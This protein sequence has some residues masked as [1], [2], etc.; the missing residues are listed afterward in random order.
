MRNPAR[1]DQCT[2]QSEAEFVDTVH[3]NKSPQQR[4]HANCRT[5]HRRGA[6]LL[7]PE[8]IDAAAKSAHGGKIFNAALVAGCLYKPRGTLDPLCFHSGFHLPSALHGPIGGQLP[9]CS[10]H[11]AADQG[12]DELVGWLRGHPAPEI[13]PTPANG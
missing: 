10:K 4:P 6:A 3:T 11:L 8:K 12:G 13:L 2:A 1:S 9:D 7:Y 5:P